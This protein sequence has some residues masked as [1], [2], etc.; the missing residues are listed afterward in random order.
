MRRLVI[1]VVLVTGLVGCLGGRGRGCY[2][3]KTC[4]DGLH[5][6]EVPTDNPSETETLCSAPAEI[7]DLSM[8]AT[9]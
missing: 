3:N 4:D 1:A 8:Q 9:R 7:V 2:P 5:C 6:F